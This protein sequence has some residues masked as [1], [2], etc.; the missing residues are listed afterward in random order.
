MK[1]FLISLVGGGTRLVEADSL[2]DE[3]NSLVI[4]RGGKVSGRYDRSKVD[5]WQELE[6]VP[7]VRSERIEY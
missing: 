1:T 3:Q 7:R 6:N 4:W 2:E 5:G